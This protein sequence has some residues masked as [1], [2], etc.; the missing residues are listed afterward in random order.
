M[1]GQPDLVEVVLAGG[2]ASRFAGRLHRGQEQAD[3][4]ADDADH[5]EQ[6]HE[7]ERTRSPFN[8]HVAILPSQPKATRTLRPASP[9]RSPSR[10]PSGRARRPQPAWEC[11]QDAAQ[12]DVDRKHRGHEAALARH[13]HFKGPRRVGNQ[14]KP[15]A[16]ERLAPRQPAPPRPRG[17]EENG[18]YEESGVRE[19]KAQRPPAARSTQ[20]PKYAGDEG[21]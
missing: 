18:Q 16:K 13:A 17:D 2:A 15:A 12:H 10:Q 4:H 8:R 5:H 1:Y 21:T 11:R 3:E 9:N 7:G 20:F 6:F 14:Q 19:L